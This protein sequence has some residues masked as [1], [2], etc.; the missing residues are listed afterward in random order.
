[1]K[2]AELIDLLKGSRRSEGSACAA[3]RKAMPTFPACATADQAGRAF[4]NGG[5]ARTMS[6]K[7]AAGEVAIEIVRADRDPE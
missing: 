5:T 6:R 1:M 2:V 7:E 3:M 4:G